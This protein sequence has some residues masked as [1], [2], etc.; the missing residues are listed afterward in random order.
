MRNGVERLSEV[1]VYTIYA[2]RPVQG[3]KNADKHSKHLLDT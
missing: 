2:T 3:F 1:Q